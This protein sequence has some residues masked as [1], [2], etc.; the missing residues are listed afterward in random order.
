MKNLKVGLLAAVAI[1][2]LLSGVAEVGA[3]DKARPAEAARPPT[4]ADVEKAR[5]SQAQIAKARVLESYRAL[6]YSD[7][8]TCDMDPCTVTITLDYFMYGG[9]TYCI[10]KFPAT[11]TFHNT[12]TTNP[13]KTINWTFNPGTVP[14]EFHVNSGILVVDDPKKQIDPDASRTN[15]VLFSAKNKHKDKGVATYV[16]VLL[17]RTAAGQPPNVCATG[18]PQIAND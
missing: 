3:Q 9:T 5:V 11:L 14:V 6:V 16:P 12:A 10:A 18:D 2:S 1:T 13:P 15:A 8:Q 17:Y 7:A 4:K